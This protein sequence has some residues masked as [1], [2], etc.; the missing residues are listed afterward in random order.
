M[1]EALIPCDD[2]S[3]RS[4]SC[5]LESF[6]RGMEGAAD[7]VGIPEPRR[8]PRVI[9]SMEDPS[10]SIA[11]IL[12]LPFPRPHAHVMDAKCPSPRLCGFSTRAFSVV[13]RARL[14]FREILCTTGT[15]I[16]RERERGREKW[17]L[18][19]MVGRYMRVREGNL[20]AMR[21]G[22]LNYFNF[23]TGG[24]NIFRCESFVIRTLN[25]DRD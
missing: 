5:T 25:E 8:F 15:I 18:K 16:K 10:R 17:R 4:P 9:E 20:R 6:A 3:T 12:C 21:A 1:D 7:K 22:W 14:R 2:T 19:I 23:R 11:D 24:G 13:N